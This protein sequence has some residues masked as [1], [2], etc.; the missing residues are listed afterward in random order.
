MKGVLST[1]GQ[2]KFVDGYTDDM[3]HAGPN[4]L[5]PPSANVYITKT[6]EAVSRD[7]FVDTGI[8]L[9]N[10][11][12]ASRPFHVPL[13]NVTFYSINGKV[14][15]VDHNNSD[16]VVDTGLSL[17]ETDGRKTR[18]GEYAG[19]IYL[20]NATDGLRQIQMGRCNDA[21]ATA[22]DA[23][24]TIDQTLA[25][26]LLAFGHAAATLRIANSTP[27]T[28][29]Y[30]AISGAGVVTLTNTLDATV[31]NDT[32]I[33]VVNDISSGKPKGSGITFWKERMIIW[34]VQADANTYSATTIDN[35]SNVIYMS[36]FANRDALENVVDF[37][38]AGTGAIEMAGKGG[39][40]TNV[41]STRDYLYAFTQTETYFAA[42]ADIDATTGGTPM[43]LLSNQYGC[44]NED[45]AADLGQGLCVF[46]TKNNRVMA[47]RVATQTGAPVVFPD[48]SFDVPVRNTVKLL[49]SDQT[50]SFFFYAP[51]DRRCYM[52]LSADSA[53]V[54]LNY[55]TEIQKMEPPTT[56]WSMGG[57]F[58]RDAVTYATELTDQTIYQ[59]GVGS[60]DNGIDF[61][62]I[63]ATSLIEDSDGR[64][65]LKLKSVGISGRISELATVTVESVVGEG[66][67]LQKDITADSG[68]STA[69][70]GSVA[71]G[72]TSLGSGIGEDLT[73]FDKLL[74]IYPSFGPSYQMRARSLG[75][76]TVTSYT[77]YGNALSKPL[78]TLS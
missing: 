10:A 57:M 42:E 15:F 74:A 12:K 72:N 44:V 67:P 73:I 9:G 69:S 70:L 60:Q 38:T 45:C 2:K 28:E 36:A 43:Q 64:T 65:T 71:I 17:T 24:I 4:N 21:A 3:R 22:G 8:S 40:V 14:Y 16:A 78:L 62:A 27:F 59:I 50:D 37:A 11:G 29:A 18:F 32:I 76:F 1:S 52:H 55:N 77:V 58:V 75:K 54:V 46:L 48:E 20:T 51:N 33:Y 7:G 34:G 19:D 13:H 25:G 49:D 30:T 56:G 68:I 39:T 66:T 31:P 53:R 41:L 47:I 35:A 61:E 5:T 26:R 63:V 23:D 6:G